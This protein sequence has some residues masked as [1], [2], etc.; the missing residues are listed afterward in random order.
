MLAQ[1]SRQRRGQAERIFH[2]VELHEA[3]GIRHGIARHREDVGA[4]NVEW[5]CHGL[6]DSR[7][8]WAAWGPPRLLKLL[9]CILHPILSAARMRLQPFAVRQFSR[10][11]AER[12]R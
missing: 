5:L 4:N 3:G 6:P 11:L 8:S 2:R 12:L 1:L 9:P 10:D 7:R